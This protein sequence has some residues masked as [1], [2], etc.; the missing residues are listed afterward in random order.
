MKAKKTKRPSRKGI[1]IKPYKGGRTKRF[2][3]RITEAEEM[4]VNALVKASGL[5]K[6]D[7]LMAIKELVQIAAVAVAW[8]ECL[9]RRHLTHAAPDVANA[10]PNC[11]C[12]ENVLTCSQCGSTYATQVS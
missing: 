11:G 12:F 10:C 7:W 1:A 8:I 2:E 9:D 3:C 6:S 4:I 5:S